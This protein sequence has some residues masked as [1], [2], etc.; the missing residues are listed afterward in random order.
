[1]SAA[2][3]EHADDPNNTHHSTSLSTFTAKAA[4]RARAAFIPDTA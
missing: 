2:R 3:F 1:L 4:D